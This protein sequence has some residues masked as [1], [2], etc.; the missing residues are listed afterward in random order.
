MSE[1]KIN[2]VITPE[3]VLET[4]TIPIPLQLGECHPRFAEFAPSEP[5]TV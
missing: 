4:A 3:M 2:N 5:R 1:A